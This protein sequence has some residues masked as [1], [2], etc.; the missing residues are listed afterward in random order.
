VSDFADARFYVIRRAV[1]AKPSTY[2]C[3]LCGE[4]FPALVEHLLVTP[5]GDPRRRR[6]AH[7]RC[8]QRARQAG[9]L[10]LREEVEPR[11]PALWRR[12]LGRH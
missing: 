3:P 2:R 1:N 10:P 12:M 8:V 6:H 5:D 7:T 4:R 11:R 9:R